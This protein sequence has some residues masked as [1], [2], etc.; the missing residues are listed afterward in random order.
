MEP[1]APAAVMR[2]VWKDASPFALGLSL[3]RGSYLSHGSAVLLHGLTQQISKTIYVNKEQSP[4]PTPT[5]SLSQE[6][7]DRAFRNQPRA[8]RYQFRFDGHT[9]TLLSG[10]NTGRLEVTQIDE[11]GERL[12]VTK[13]ERTLIDIAVRPVYAGGV[14][15]VLKAYEAARDR[16][17]VNTL[18]AT[19]KRLEY[20]YPYHQ[21]IGFYMQRAGFAKKHLEKL[22]ALGMPFQFYLTN[23]IPVPK[24]DADWQLWV[25]EE[26]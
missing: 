14:F 26:L 7:I 4:K 21:A 12:D 23:R 1:F 18:V 9:A 3:G 5:G 19:L 15:E 10:K 20:V 24:L 22:R 2:Y 16:A 25:P 13:L 8:S 11:N 17:S 6:A